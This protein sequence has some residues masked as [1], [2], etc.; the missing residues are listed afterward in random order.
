MLDIKI[1]NG[2]IID[3]TGKERYRADIGIKG[4]KIIRIGK[5][6]EDAEKIIDAE[7]KLVCP[8]FIDIHTHSDVSVIYDRC[9]SSKIRDGVTS[10]VIGNCGIAVAPIFEEKKDY[11]LKYLATRLIGSIPVELKLPWNTLDEYF[12][13]IDN[14]PPA[15]NIIPLLAQGVVRINEMDFSKAAPTDEQ[16]NNM[17]KIVNESMKAGTFAITS[18]LVYLP[19]D[20]TSTEELIE[21]CK[22]VKKY[23]GYYTTHMRTESDGIF[24]ALEE[25]ITIAEK[26]EIPLHISHLKIAGLKNRGK[27]DQLLQRIEKAQADG[28][29]VT[30]DVYPYDAG[31]TSLSSLLPPWGFE[32]GVE[33][34]IERLREKE[35]RE[36]MR[37]DIKTGIK[38][39]Q[40]SISTLGSWDEV[41]IA[42]V[43]NEESHLLEGKSI[44]EIAEMW[45]KDPLETVFDIVQKEKGRVQVILKRMSEND[46]REIIKHPLAIVCSDAMSLSETGILSQGKPHPRAFGSH[47]RVISKYARDLNLFSIEDAIKKMTSMPANRLGLKNRGIL[48]EDYYAD[49]TIIDLE[50][51]EDRA[52]YANP[53]QYSK[54]IDTV[55][56]NGK[57]ALIND[58]ET[59]EFSGVV[60]K[61]GE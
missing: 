26:S 43:F 15:V 6:E 17:K 61:R 22:E 51:I 18:G 28:L 23:N 1:I 21:L 24:E 58:E 20:Y 56:V 13:F 47:A 50:E 35:I 33:K 12:D 3:G 38:G 40:N 10:E 19:G 41:V 9:A 8:G 5:I 39:W 42:S 46:V 55:I 36:Q 34:L 52:T 57:I 49:I 16:L 25:A 48:A 29:D 31:L 44:R 53:K 60:L 7:N 45:K 37:E 59:K 2:K 32:G 4:N 30:F 27:T 54:G 14:T 11:L